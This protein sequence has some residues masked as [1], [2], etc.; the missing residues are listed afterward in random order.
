[1]QKKTNKRSRDD[2]DM[3][4]E[5]ITYDCNQCGF[6]GRLASHLDHHVRNVHENYEVNKKNSHLADPFEDDN[7]D[8]K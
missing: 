3:D 5:S 1:M 2:I 4:D 8:G 7:N 6:N